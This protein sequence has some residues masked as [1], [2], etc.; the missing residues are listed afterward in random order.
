MA[1]FLKFVMHLDDELG[2]LVQHYGPTT[3]AILFAVI[4]LETGFVIFPF[5]P[6]DSLLFALGLLSRGAEGKE[7]AFNV[8]AVFFLLSFAAICGDQVNYRIG[9]LFGERL[10]KNPNSKIFRRS[11]LEKTQAFYEQHGPKAVMLARFVPVVRA[12]APFVAGMGHMEY[13]TFCRYSI[14]GALLWVG[15]CVGAGF[16][17]G[18]IPL[19]RDNFEYGILGIVLLSAIPMGIE[20]YKHKQKPK[21]AKDALATETRS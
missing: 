2:K 21:V 19:V 13:A 6:G 14:M 11:H 5:L 3:Y 15:A 12:V 20:V 7:P 8:A 9:K 1:D 10:Y 17:L 4:F 16:G 18:S